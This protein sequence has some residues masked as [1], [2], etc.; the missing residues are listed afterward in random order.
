MQQELFDVY[1][2]LLG[3]DLATHFIAQLL[4]EVTVNIQK[5]TLV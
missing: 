1:L 2:E 5:L 3:S 4:T